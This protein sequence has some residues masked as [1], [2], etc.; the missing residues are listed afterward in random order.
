MACPVSLVITHMCPDSSGIAVSFGWG[1]KPSGSTG[2]G[3]AAS[4]WITRGVHAAAEGT[5]GHDLGASLLDPLHERSIRR[6]DG[7]GLRRLGFGDEL[8]D[9]VI[10]RVASPPECEHPLARTTPARRQVPRLAIEHHDDLIAGGLGVVH[11]LVDEPAH[12]AI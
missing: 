3:T 2:A 8:R 7:D 1:T 5:G 10:G 12:S 6:H 11:E 9:V 4:P